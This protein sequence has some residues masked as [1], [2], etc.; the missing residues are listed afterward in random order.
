MK[1]TRT[2]RTDFALFQ[3]ECAR[4]L[5][6]FGLTE[7]RASFKWRQLD[8]DFAQTHINIQGRCAAFVLSK[9]WPKDV[10]HHS[11]VR[12]SALHEVVHLLVYDVEHLVTDRVVTVEL[13]DRTVEAL[14][15]RIQH[16]LL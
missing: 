8:E 7:W 12:S 4:W 6:R 11:Q 1:K 14:V 5:Q 15:R 2:T 13:K 9:A 10:S 3:A 16:A